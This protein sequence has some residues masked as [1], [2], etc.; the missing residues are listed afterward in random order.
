VYGRPQQVLFMTLLAFAAASAGAQAWPTK[1]VKAIVPIAAGSVVDLAPRA[2]FEQ[3]GTQLGQVIVVEN[4]PGAGQT[5]GTGVAARA[6]PDGY[7]WLV[8]SSAHAVA[9][10]FNPSLPYQPA[11]DFAA[12]VPLGVT[13][14]VLVVPA[15]RGFRTAR[16]LVAAAKAKP[17]SFNFSS[18]GVGSASHLSAERFRLSAGIKAEHVPFKGG[19]E[20]MTEV[21]AGR[22]DF[23]FIALGAMLPHARAGKL[24]ALAVNGYSRS[25]ALPDVPTL[26]EAGYADAEYPMWIGVFV[27][28]R[29]PREIVDRVYLETTKALQEP[30]VKAKLAA[31]GMDPMRL[32]PAAFDALVVNDLAVNAALVKAVGLE[33]R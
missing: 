2:V 7:T 24:V 1:P 15:D 30:A 21:I 14:F 4:R 31:L 5:V 20:A 13:P 10:A 11:R 8:N 25:P 17:G 23:A 28:A 12:V 22:V 18:P 6:D 29:T 27:P 26:A 3:L 33:P 16:D 19:V 32:T 9:P